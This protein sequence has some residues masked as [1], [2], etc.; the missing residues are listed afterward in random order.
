[1]VQW[2]WD[3]GLGCSECGASL[4]EDNR[5]FSFAPRAYLCQDCATLRGGVYD[6]RSN[7]WSTPPDVRDIRA[8]HVEAYAPLA[9]EQEP[10]FAPSASRERS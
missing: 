1:M 3:I 9:Q 7:A 6:A 10:A 8:E 2:D 5:T 4:W